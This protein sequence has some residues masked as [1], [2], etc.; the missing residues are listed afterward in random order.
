MDFLEWA[1]KRLQ[2][3]IL[4][5]IGARDIFDEVLNDFPDL[6]HRLKADAEIVESC[7]FETAVV[8]IMTGQEHNLNREEVD[9][10]QR[11]RQFPAS[12]NNVSGRNA[13]GVAVSWPSASKRKRSKQS[14]QSALTETQ[15]PAK[16]KRTPSDLKA[17]VAKRA[18]AREEDMSVYLDLKG[19]PATS[20]EVERLFSTIKCTLGY[21][22]KSLS[23]ETL[24][25]ILYLRM[26]WDQVTNEVTLKAVK[27]EREE[28]VEG[29]E[30]CDS[31]E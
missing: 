28:D 19:L 18:Q 9:A 4:T 12:E 17:A 21:L 29:E 2:S 11:L 13:P 8:K 10:V 14:G 22:R 26:N 15:P 5:I 7:I 25:M 31:L 1:T 23:A 27:C 24:E 30:E 6:K 20:V 3:D 16:K